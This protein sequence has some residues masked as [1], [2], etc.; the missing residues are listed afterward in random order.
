[1]RLP[2]RAEGI[3]VM[4]R[5]SSAS[6]AARPSPSCSEAP[7][8]WMATLTGPNAVPQMV[9]LPGAVGDAARLLQQDGG[10]RPVKG[11]PRRR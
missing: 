5:A 3:A 9:G 7:I 1:M 10:H 2:T 8:A 4:S 6:A 11:H